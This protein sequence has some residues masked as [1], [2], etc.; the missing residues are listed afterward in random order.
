MAAK[1]P[2]PWLIATGTSGWLNSALRE[3]IP[4][5]RQ[6]P[7]PATRQKSKVWLQCCNW[8]LDPSGAV[9]RGGSIHA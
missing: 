8:K 3:G 5:R 7:A 9:R 2:L 1:W 6:S 4:T